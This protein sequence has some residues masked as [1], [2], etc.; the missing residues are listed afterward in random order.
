MLW[1]VRRIA[2]AKIPFASASAAMVVVLE[3]AL[4]AR[5]ADDALGRCEETGRGASSTWNDVALSP[6]PPGAVLLVM[7][8]RVLGRVLSS[9]AAGELRGD[10]AVVPSF[11][12]ASAMSARE[13]RREPKLAPFARDMALTGVPEEWSLAQ[14][15]AARPLATTFDARWERA[16]ARHLVPAGLFAIFQPEP[17]GTSDRRRALDALAP[18]HALLQKAILKPRDPELCAATATLLRVRA[19]A[20]VA[21]G[22]REL[23][24]RMLDDLRPFS[25]NDS[26]ANEL[27]RRVTLAKGVVE[28]KDLSP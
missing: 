26:L 3:L 27:I 23:L 7:D 13:I 18:A 10:V 8:R 17:R 20:T 21:S 15:A 6:L 24:P 4:P 5:A 22:D 28:V 19:I 11:D 9:A 16:L 2:Q 12:L 14:L 25:P 1:I